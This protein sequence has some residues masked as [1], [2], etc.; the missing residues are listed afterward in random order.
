MRRLSPA[1]RF[2]EREATMS[3]HGDPVPM[4]ARKG[5]CRG[6]AEVPGDKSISH[7]ALILGAMA[8]ARPHHR[9][10]E[11]QD[12]LD[13]AKAMRAFG[14]EVSSTARALARAWR[15]RRRLRGARARDRLRQFR[16]RR[17]ADHG[18]DGDLAD[19]R[20]LHRRRQPAQAPHGA[21]HRSAGAVRR[22]GLRARG[23]AA[24]DDH[25][26]RAPTRCRCATRCRCRRRR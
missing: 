25:R 11:G 5:P 4:T 19:H 13:T 24:A 26:G 9:L 7:R 3:G 18:G 14:A 23:R 10:L 22:A 12:V 17:A 6:T 16:H 2:S 15:R 21:R 1:H 20:H 8:W